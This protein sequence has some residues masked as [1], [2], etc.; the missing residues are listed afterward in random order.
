MV[1]I[2]IGVVGGLGFSKWIESRQENKLVSLGS[3][4]LFYF[5]LYKL[6]RRK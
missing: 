2:L 6:L 4:L 1:K 5:V 3:E